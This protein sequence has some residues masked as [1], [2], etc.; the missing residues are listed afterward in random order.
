MHSR[1]AALL[2]VCALLAFFASRA[3]AE[4][5]PHPQA[6]RHPGYVLLTTKAY[7]PPDFDQQTFDAVWQT[8]EEP[9]R[10]KAAAATLAERRKMALERYGL[11]SAEGDDPAKPQQYVVDSAGNWTMNC[12]ACHQGR[13]A[14]RVI[15]GVPNTLLAL[16]TLTD[17]IR[18]TKAQLKKRPTRMEIGSLFMP[19][20]TSNGTTN[21]VMFGVALLARRDAQLNV[22]PLAF[23]PPMVHHDEDAPAWW[24]FKKK[25]RIYVDAFVT[26]GHRALMQFLLV[27]ENGPERFREWEDDFR[28]IYRYLESLEPP[29]YPFAIDGPLAARGKQAFDAHCARCHGTYGPGGS[30]PDR[31]VPIAEV[32][33]DRVRFGS[34]SK[35]HRENFAKTWFTG[36]GALVT[37][38]EPKGYLAPPLDGVWASAPY[39]HNGSVPTLW[40]VLHPDERPRVWLRSIDGYD[41]RRVGLEVEALRA[42]PRAAATAR[43]RR[44]YFDTHGFGKSAAGHLFPNELEE[45]EKQA[46]L[47]YLKTL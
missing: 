47:E 14:G 45:A 3:L 1:R 19:L 8:W 22:L 4:S 44:R 13:V 40:H 36:Y 38:I 2:S 34:L 41:Q 26:K 32:A 43:D 24:L 16:Q 7:L 11:T 10:S 29:A 17:E 6:P 46:V 18:Q 21:A 30:Y 35:E 25:S 9:L 42:V 39:L 33:T 12:L 37:D 28:E 27:R 20:G 31:V 23:P 15:P 5:T